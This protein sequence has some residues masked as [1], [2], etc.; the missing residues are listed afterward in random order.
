MEFIKH[1][2]GICGEHWHPSVLTL[3]VAGGVLK[4]ALTYLSGI[5]KNFFN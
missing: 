4:T 1:A 5:A 3:F 2:L